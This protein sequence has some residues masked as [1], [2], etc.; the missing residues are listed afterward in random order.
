MTKL[1]LIPLVL[2]L[3]FAGPAQAQHF[4]TDFTE[5]KAKSKEEGKTIVL[6]FSGSDWC[7]PCIRLK[8]EILLAPTFT[9]FSEKNLVVV[10]LD[11]PFRK[12]NELPPAQK[13]HNESLAERY[14]PQGDFPLVL[15]LNPDES[16]AKSIPYKVSMPAETFI[17]EIASTLTN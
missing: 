7:K 14:N 3:C 13:Q 12:K 17:Q 6:V 10:N 5:A 4:E 8:K 1:T 16:I 9:D 2:L 15:I 11:F